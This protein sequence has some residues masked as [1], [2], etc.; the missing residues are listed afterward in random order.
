IEVFDGRG[1]V[2]RTVVDSVG[3]RETVVRVVGSRTISRD[4]VELIIALALIRLTAF[5]SALEKVVEI[6]VARVV[7]FTAD[8]STVA[9]GNRRER[10]QRILVEAAKQSKQYYLPALDSPLTFDQVTSIPAASKIMFAECNG[11]PL[12]SALTSPPVLC[13]IGP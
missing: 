12:K 9:S 11:G 8:R 6:G 1:T 5:E 4:P 10:W 3:K 7:P 2:W 13:L